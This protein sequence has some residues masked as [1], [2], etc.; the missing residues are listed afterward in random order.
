MSAE[1]Q[2]AAARVNAAITA[3]KA[4][5]AS[6]DFAKYGQALTDLE[7]AM[8]AFVVAQRAESPQTP[9]V[10]PPASPPAP[11]GLPAPTPSS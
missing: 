4:A 11:T 8:D 2:A 6:G 10:S 7:A 1:L 3:V 9:P 5:Q